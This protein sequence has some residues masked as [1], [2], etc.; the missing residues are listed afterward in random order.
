[1]HEERLYIPDTMK[2]K[3]RRNREGTATAKL[4]RG[5]QLN[6]DRDSVCD[7][8]RDGKLQKPR[9]GIGVYFEGIIIFYLFF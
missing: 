1:M 4:G 5:S 7:R 2:I 3:P 9:P 8:D 6:R